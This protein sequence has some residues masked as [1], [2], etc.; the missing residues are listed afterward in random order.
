MVSMPSPAGFWILENCC[1]VSCYFVE[2]VGNVGGF[3]AASIHYM[4]LE[5]T[6]GHEL[7]ISGAI[8]R[9]RRT[10][11]RIWTNR[12][13]FG[14][15]SLGTLGNGKAAAPPPATPPQF[16]TA[17]FKGSAFWARN[18]QYVPR[19]VASPARLFF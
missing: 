17:R 7:L 5:T 11:F 19:M 13:S 2:G 10:G 9:P 15:D 12:F 4:E 6:L 14:L 3:A 1:N 16:R 8:C 18:P